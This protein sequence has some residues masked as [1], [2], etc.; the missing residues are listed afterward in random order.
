M[1]HVTDTSKDFNQLQKIQSEEDL[2][3]YLCDEVLLSYSNILKYVSIKKDRKINRYVI[4]DNNDAEIVTIAL[5]FL[6]GCAQQIYDLIVYDNI[7][8]KGMTS[9]LHVNLVNNELVY[10]RAY[11][12]DKNNGMLEDCFNNYQTAIH[13]N[14]LVLIIRE[15][16]KLIENDS[17]NILIVHYKNYYFV[18]DCLP[19]KH[20]LDIVL[21]KNSHQ[22]PIVAITDHQYE[23]QLIYTILEK[24]KQ[25]YI[26]RYPKNIKFFILSLIFSQS[27]Q[28][29][30]RF[31]KLL[32]KKGEQ[33]WNNE[34]FYYVTNGIE[35]YLKAV[36]SSLE[37]HYITLL[38]D[39]LIDIVDEGLKLMARK[40]HLIII[41]YYKKH[42][43]IA[44]QLL[45]PYELDFILRYPGNYFRVKSIGALFN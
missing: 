33:V 11:D 35:I 38:K 8:T 45:T 32:S 19:S 29:V 25:L 28:E 7:V 17:Q 15:V 27:L 12:F 13:W 37:E 43:F 6:D 1:G 2:I 44:D 23:N 26:P 14:S 22:Y 3:T 40:S 4:G 16:L 5:L 30:M 21:K 20:D 31:K 34:T 42:F 18:A 24:N 9:Y 36:L 41:I 39:T 10:L